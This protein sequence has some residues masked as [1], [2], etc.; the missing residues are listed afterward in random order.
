MN[1]NTYASLK[2]RYTTAEG[3][4]CKDVDKGLH[5]VPVTVDFMGQ[6]GYDILGAYIK[7]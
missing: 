7:Y 5:Q 1:I 3:K 6:I 4:K 2:T